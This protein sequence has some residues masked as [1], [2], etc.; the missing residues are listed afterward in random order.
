MLLVRHL[1]KVRHL[2]LS[3]RPRRSLTKMLILSLGV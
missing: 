2:A 1:A 3:L